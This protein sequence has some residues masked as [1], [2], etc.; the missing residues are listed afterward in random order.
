[1]SKYPK[2]NVK[3]T[4]TDS[5]AFSIIG[6]VKTA[7]RTN[8]VPDVEVKMFLDEA[9]SGDYNK[10]IQTAMSWVNVR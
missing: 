1:M 8:G 5:N 2:I 6:K 7:L 9:M 10:V 4:G 3:L